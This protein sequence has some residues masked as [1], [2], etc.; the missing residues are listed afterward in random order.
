MF[1]IQFGKQQQIL[2]RTGLIVAAALLSLSCSNSPEETKSHELAPIVITHASPIPTTAAALQTVPTPLAQSSMPPPKSDEVRQAMT[3][4]F[5]KAL[6]LDE[7]HTPSFLIGDFNG[8]GSE[9]LAV[10]GSSKESS[11]PEIN[12]ELANW[13]LEDPRLVPLPGA[14]VAEQIARSKPVQAEKGDSLLAIIHGVGAKGWRN[15]EARQTY[16]LKT[17]AGSNMVVQNL[18][19][20]R[21]TDASLRL[22]SIKGDVISQRL[23]SNSGIL[24]WTGA[25]YAWFPF[26]KESK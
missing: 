11:L 13:T 7:H 25:K 19:R 16:L 12:N 17:G 15:P 8:D 21:S 14:K 2:V 23:G 10:V 3:R 22:P 9:D 24:F 20:M 18:D 5:D 26:A 4:V 1:R 6:V